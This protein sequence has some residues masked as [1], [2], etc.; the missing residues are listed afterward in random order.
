MSSYYHALMHIVLMLYV[1]VSHESTSICQD[2][3]GTGQDIR[4]IILN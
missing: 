2:R 3:L 1:P 4:K